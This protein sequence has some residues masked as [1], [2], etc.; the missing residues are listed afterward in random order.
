M[1]PEQVD[2]VSIAD[3]VDLAVGP[4]PGAALAAATAVKAAGAE[5]FAI[6]LGTGAASAISRVTAAISRVGSEAP[7]GHR[8]RLGFWVRRMTGATRS[9]PIHR[10]DNN[11][12][13]PGIKAREL[14]YFGRFNLPRRHHRDRR[15]PLV[16]PSRAR[17]RLRCESAVDQ[18]LD[19]GWRNPGG[20]S[21]VLARRAEGIV[22]GWI[23]KQLR[24]INRA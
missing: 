19:R 7:L 22:A 24:A 9:A 3:A 6:G 21:Q 13:T 16:C 23:E 14:G 20:E 18:P 4:D 5:V 8:Q 17:R 1:P 10:L 12:W 11:V 2:R 15:P